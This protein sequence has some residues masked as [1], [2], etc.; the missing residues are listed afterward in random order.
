M[1][2]EPIPDKCCKKCGQW[3][4][5]TTE[6]FYAAKSCRDKLHNT[7]K[8]CMCKEQYAKSDKVKARARVRE[9]YR[10][11]PARY[12]AYNSPEGRNAISRR[13][14]KR[15]P[16]RTRTSKNASRARNAAHYNAY[17]KHYRATHPEQ[18]KATYQ[19]RQARKRELP[20]D[21]TADDWQFALDY[22]DHHCAICERPKGLWHTLA[23]D[24][25]IPLT[26]IG[27]PG[28]VPTNIIPLCQGESGCNNSKSNSMPLDWLTLKFGPRKARQILA[29][30]ETYFEIVK[31]RH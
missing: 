15:Y 19:R 31:G 25:W 5:R 11:D 14:R 16:D 3:F 28:T 1:L 4:P 26:A 8:R 27:C 10:E 2:Y 29:R 30:I 6:F 17:D 13:Y 22:F 23:A 12:M 21:F 20:D 24:H 7:C 18:G 9:F